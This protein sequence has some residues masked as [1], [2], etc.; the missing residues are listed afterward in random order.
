VKAGLTQP[1]LIP[2]TLSK[3]QLGQ[4]RSLLGEGVPVGRHVQQSRVKMNAC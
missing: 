4:C 1:D 3:R 2:D